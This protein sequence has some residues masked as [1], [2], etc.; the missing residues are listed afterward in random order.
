MRTSIRRVIVPFCAVGVA[1]AAP[2]HGQPTD[3]AAL[4]GRWTGTYDCAQGATALELHLRG[5]ENGI[6]R[7][8]FQFAPTHDNPETPAG[9][10]PV[11]GRLSGTS[12]VLRPIDARGLPAEYVPVGIQ[13]AVNG[14]RITGWIDGPGCGAM[15]VT[16]AEAA[17]ADEALPGGYGQQRWATLV[18]VEAGRLAMD[19]RA[20]EDGGVSVARTWMRWETLRDEAD[21]GL[22]AGEVTEMEVEMDCAA[23]LMRT[24]H[25]LSYAP[26]GELTQVDAL[27]PYGWQPIEEESIFDLVWEHACFGA[28]LPAS[29]A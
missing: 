6:V 8:T 22:R 28:E 10:Y 2:A 26:G 4:S 23:P 13:A 27:V 18:E 29:K 20:R 25:L 15:A 21:T 12:L 9:S 1:V 5:L 14:R 19:A 3:A 24:W 7:G 16:R 17:R 11:M